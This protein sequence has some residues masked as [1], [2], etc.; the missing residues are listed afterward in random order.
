MNRV[1]TVQAGVERVVTIPELYF[2]EQFVRPAESDLPDA[3]PHL[4]YD[5]QQK[6]QNP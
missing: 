5:Q 2:P 6:L 1:P 3:H 4:L